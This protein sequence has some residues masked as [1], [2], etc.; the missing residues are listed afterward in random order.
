[1][2]RYYEVKDPLCDIIM[3]GAEAW[4]LLTGWEI[5]PGE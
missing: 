5:P 1:M 2:D 3:D 4:A